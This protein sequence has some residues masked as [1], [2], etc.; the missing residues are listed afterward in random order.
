M[1]S[2]HYKSAAFVLQQPDV[3]TCQRRDARTLSTNGEFSRSMYYMYDGTSLLKAFDR[4]R[5]VVLSQTPELHF[6]APGFPHKI[7]MHIVRTLTKNVSAV[8]TFSKSD[9]ELSRWTSAVCS[10]Q[11]VFLNMFS[12]LTLY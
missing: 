4:L 7:S 8:R 11:S 5:D 6:F 3:D 9:R 2:R 10:H 12:S 1:Y